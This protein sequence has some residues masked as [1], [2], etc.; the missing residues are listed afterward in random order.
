MDPPV[1]TLCDPV[2]EAPVFEPAAPVLDPAPWL[3]VL[4]AALL[5]EFVPVSTE[6]FAL[7]EPVPVCDPPACLLFSFVPAA[8][9][10]EPVPVSF[11]AFALALLAELVP[12]A[13]PPLP[14]LF[15]PVPVFEPPFFEPWVD[16]MSW[17]GVGV[18]PLFVSCELLGALIVS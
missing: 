5:A 1:E 18:F 7:C 11:E 9:L 16:F 2:P 17:P 12:L 14:L 10:A 4:L 15:D 6:P 13:E 3:L 8:L